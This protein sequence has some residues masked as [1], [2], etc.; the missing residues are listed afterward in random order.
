MATG[1]APEEIEVSI[2]GSGFG[3]CVVVH[4][5]HEMVLLE[6][7][8]WL[9]GK[10]HRVDF[11]TSKTRAVRE[12]RPSPTASAATA[13]GIKHLTPPLYVGVS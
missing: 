1:P 10:D 2:F 4:T 11:A 5:A 12:A 8:S 9:L 13:N 7:R 6:Q 3:E